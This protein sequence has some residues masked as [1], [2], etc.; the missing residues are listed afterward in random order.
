[1][2]TFSPLDIIRALK[3]TE[4]FIEMI[5]MQGG[6]YKFHEFLR[7]LYPY[8]AELYINK[9]KNHVIT[10]IK[11]KYYDISG[12]VNNNDRQYRKADDYDI[13]KVREWS[14]SKNYMLKVGECPACEEPICVTP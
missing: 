2:T 8:D 4:P 7:T 3:E 11:G 12:L 9:D 1:M 14:F 13:A 10:R 5:F 6:C